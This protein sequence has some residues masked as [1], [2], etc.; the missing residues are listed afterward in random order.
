MRGAFFLVCASTWI[1][2]KMKITKNR[3]NG[4]SPWPGYIL[5]RNN[6]NLAHYN[7]MPEEPAVRKI[8][9]SFSDMGSF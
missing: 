1:F 9:L 7:P 3:R 8:T 4:Q 2:E 6:Q 5:R